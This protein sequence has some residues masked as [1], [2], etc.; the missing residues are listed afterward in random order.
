MAGNHQ[1]IILGLN[2][3]AMDMEKRLKE[4]LAGKV[5]TADSVNHLMDANIGANHEHIEE[6]VKQISAQ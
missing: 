6:F 1:S 5:M 3:R 4:T 2:Q